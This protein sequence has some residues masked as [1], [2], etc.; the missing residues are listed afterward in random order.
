[1][2]ARCVIS[3]RYHQP[4]FWDSVSP[5]LELTDS[6]RLTGQQVL[7]NPPTFFLPGSS[8]TGTNLH[9]IY[10]LSHTLCP[11]EYLVR[12]IGQFPITLGDEILMC[13]IE[14][15][16]RVW[17]STIFAWAQKKKKKKLAPSCDSNLKSLNYTG[18]IDRPGAKQY[19]KRSSNRILE[20]M[21]LLIKKKKIYT[22]EPYFYFST[23]LKCQKE[24]GQGVWLVSVNLT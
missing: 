7:G 13:L 6:A 1:M 14:K 3:P 23:C 18:L 24:S 16:I 9:T 21:C 4:H 11:P 8:H 12:C 2:E 20:R 19:L 17:Q 22:L 5:D 10:Q 15:T